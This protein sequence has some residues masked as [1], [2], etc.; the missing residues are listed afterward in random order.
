MNRSSCSWVAAPSL[1]PSG[2]MVWPKRTSAGYNPYVM[3][4]S[5]CC[6]EG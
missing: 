3:S 5:D 2:G 6:E 1:N 4:S